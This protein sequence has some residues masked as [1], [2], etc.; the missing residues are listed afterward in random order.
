MGDQGQAYEASQAQIN[1]RFAQAGRMVMFK[2]TADGLYKALLDDGTFETFGAPGAGAIQVVK[3]A[4]T[5]AQVQAI[6]TV[7]IEIIAA[8]GVGNTIDVISVITRMNFNTTAYVANLDLN[9]I[10]NTAADVVF[11]ISDALGGGATRIAKG[12]PNSASP[13]G[14]QILENQGVNVTDILGDPTIG[15]NSADVY[16]T[17]RTVAL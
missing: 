6:N 10:F 5:T 14:L 7:P 4:L 12:T 9:L 16:V 13:A 8:P 15:D 1:A 2:D 17:F 3:L 11:T